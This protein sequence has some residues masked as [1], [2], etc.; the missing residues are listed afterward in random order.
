MT[1]PSFSPSCRGSTTVQNLSPLWGWSSGVSPR[2]AAGPESTS[3]NCS[4]PCSCCCSSC[5]SCPCSCCCC[6]CCCDSV[7]APP[8]A[9]EDASL[10]WLRVSLVG[11]P[12]LGDERPCSSVAGRTGAKKLA[13]AWR[14]IPDAIDWASGTSEFDTPATRR[15]TGGAAE[16][17]TPAIGSARPN[18]SEGGRDLSSV[19]TTAVL[20]HSAISGN[21]SWLNSTPPPPRVTGYRCPFVKI[22]TPRS[23][24][25]GKAGKPDAAAQASQRMCSGPAQLE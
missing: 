24:D 17:K 16:R 11:G 9:A 21:R 19:T 20:R 10:V 4:C 2:G 6:C 1:A 12:R 8:G 25:C 13:T 5:C 15:C 22:V 23:A 7:S 18:C 3:R 14:T